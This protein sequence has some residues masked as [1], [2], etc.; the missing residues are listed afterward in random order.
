MAWQNDY[1]DVA[2]RLQLFYELYP[3]GVIQ[4]MPAEIKT[5]G[6]KQFIAVMAHGYKTPDDKLP[7]IAQAWE[8]AVGATNFTRNSEAMNAETSAVGRM[9]GMMGIAAKKSIASKDEIANRQGENEPAEAAKPFVALMETISKA[10]T[11]KDLEAAAAVIKSSKL[12]PDHLLALRDAYAA[13][14]KVIQP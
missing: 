11:E 10:V 1:V 6:D 12:A 3:N 4:C 2:T 7:Y 5:I 14:Q 9:L 8:P 13:R